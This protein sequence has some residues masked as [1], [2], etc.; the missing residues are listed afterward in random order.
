M[1]FLD[2][3]ALYALAS[4]RDPR[5]REAVRIAGALAAEEEPLLLHT[6]ILCEAFSLV[7]RRR[8]MQAALAMDSGLA[9][10]EIVVVDLPLHG[11]AVARQRS[12]D[13]ARVSL[14]DAVSFV[15]MEDWGIDVAFA[16]DPDFER[17]GFRLR[18]GR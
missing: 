18:G 11:R 6:Y 14:V 7:H 12:G 10:H 1:T 3:S 13:S 16:F 2:T 17:A 15:V 8:G 5:H 9:L 4:D